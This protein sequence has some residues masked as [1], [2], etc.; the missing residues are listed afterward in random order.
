MAT[1]NDL[2]LNLSDDIVIDPVVEALQVRRADL[3][4]LGLAGY[5]A[6]YDYY[7][8]RTGKETLSG[9]YWRALKHPRVRWIAVA[10]ATS[11]FKHLVLPNLAPKADPLMFLAERWHRSAVSTSS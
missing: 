10:T 6:A 7:A 9:A 5:V 8:I 4:W 3:A 1:D 11:V 2:Q